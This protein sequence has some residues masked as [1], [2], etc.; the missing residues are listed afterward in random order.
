MRSVTTYCVM[1][2]MPSTFS[3]SGREGARVRDDACEDVEVVVRGEPVV[4]GE[5]EAFLFD[6]AVVDVELVHDGACGG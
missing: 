6:A 1:K 4:D 2:S 5:F 3:F